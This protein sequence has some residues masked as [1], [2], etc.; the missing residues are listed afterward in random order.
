MKF[1]APL[2]AAAL[3]LSAVPASAGWVSRT[4]AA[5]NTAESKA[6]LLK[7]MCASSAPTDVTLCERW[8]ATGV[9]N[10]DIR[11]AIGATAVVVGG[12]TGGALFLNPGVIGQKTFHVVGWTPGFK[13]AVV[14]GAG[15]ALG[16]AGAGLAVDHY[17]G[18]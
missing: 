1:F 6:A 8:K 10:S 15:T 9:P 4:N 2:V 5:L 16:V 18:K 7:R 14:L 11:Y 13:K 12:V 3:A 17:I